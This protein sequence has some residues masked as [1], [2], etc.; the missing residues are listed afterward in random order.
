MHIVSTLGT[1][2]QFFNPNVASEKTPRC[3]LESTK[4]TSLYDI[5]ENNE[6]M[7]LFMIKEQLDHFRITKLNEEERKDP[8]AWR[9]HEVQ[10]FYVEFV[11]IQILGIVELQ[12]E[13]RSL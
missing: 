9:D 5:M 11:T 8:L 7:V 2:T 6:E 10:F 13:T 12:I 4:K 1:C 3:T